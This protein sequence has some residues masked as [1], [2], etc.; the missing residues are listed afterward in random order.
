MVQFPNL[1]LFKKNLEKSKD[2]Q[3][4]DKRETKNPLNETIID[5]LNSTEETKIFKI[6]NEVTHLL[7]LTDR[8]IEGYSIMDFIKLPFK[9]ILRYVFRVIFLLLNIFLICFVLSE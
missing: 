7:M 5:I 4:L 8:K 2:T 3:L 6:S 9:T 1:K